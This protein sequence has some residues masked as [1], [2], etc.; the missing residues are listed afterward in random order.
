MGK[1]KW[2]LVCGVLMAALSFNVAAAGP[3]SDTNVF[4]AEHATPAFSAVLG[5]LMMSQAGGTELE[6][7]LSVSNTCAAPSLDLGT[8][9]PTCGVESTGPVWLFC[10]A[11][12]GSNWAFASSSDLINGLPIGTGLNDLGELEPGGT[13]TVYLSE[14]IEAVVGEGAEEVSFVGYC[15]VVGQN[16]EAIAGTYVNFLPLAGI[17]QDFALQ[18]DFSGVPIGM[19]DGM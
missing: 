1:L 15:W 16:F 11:Q 7:A 9:F 2:I 3:K 10:N 8:G 19:P 6:T 17:Q 18:S 14:V 5:S 4:F 12:D 13:W